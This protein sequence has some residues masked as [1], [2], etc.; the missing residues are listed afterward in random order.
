MDH[1]RIFFVNKLFYFLTISL[2]ITSCGSYQYSGYLNDGIYDNNDSSENNV[3][4][5]EEEINDEQINDYYKSAFSEKASIYAETEASDQLF[6]DVENYRT[7]ENDTIDNYGPWGDQKDSVVI[8][9]H[10]SHHDGFWSRW[11]YPNWMWNYGFGYGGLNTWGYGYNNYWSRP[12]PYYG[13]IYNPFNPFWGYYDSYYYGYGYGGYYYGYYPW[14]SPYNSWYNY[15]P[16]GR[17]FNTNVSL[18]NGRRNPRNMISSRSNN[19]SNTSISDRFDRSSSVSLSDRLNRIDRINS[20]ARVNPNM[21]NKPFNNNTTGS[22]NSLSK[23]TNNSGNGYYNN[24]S[25]PNN[26]YSRP[27]NNYSKPSNNYNSSGSSSGGSF[28]RPSSSY[29]PSSNSSYSRGGGGI[30]SGS[31]SS[32]GGKSGR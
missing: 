6:T 30:S 31:S 21:Y 15:S 14:M 9:I 10:S 12:F 29:S 18:V 32:R 13:G 8:N 4:T 27:S 19:F 22:S 28:S 2:F 7:T 5:G 11:R 3:I 17:N 1:K 23:P 24:N 25:K 26:S 16:Y 20:S